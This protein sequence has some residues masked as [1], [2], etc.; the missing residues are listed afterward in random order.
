MRI[1]AQGFPPDTP[2]PIMDPWDQR[3]RMTEHELYE[4]VSGRAADLG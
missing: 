4:T 1:V 2:L 3:F